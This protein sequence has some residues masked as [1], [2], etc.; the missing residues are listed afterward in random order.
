MLLTLKS[1]LKARQHS[2]LHPERI[3]GNAENPSALHP[4]GPETGLWEVQDS[5]P[6]PVGETS[7]GLPRCAS[8]VQ[9][10]PAIP[11]DSNRNDWL[12]VGEPFAI[13]QMPSSGLAATRRASVCISDQ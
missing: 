2:I 11:S 1:V 3:V 12:T 5:S 10:C 4:H 13:P 7:R 6:D 8:C 9:G